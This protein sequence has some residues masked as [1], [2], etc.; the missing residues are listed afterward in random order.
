[1]GRSVFAALPLAALAAFLAAAPVLAQRS[2]TR[3]LNLG[4]HLSGAS[5]TVQDDDASSAGGGGV[6]AGYGINRRF[7]LFLQI[8]G[9]EFDVEDAE[10]E[11]RWT[12]AHV[13][14][15]ARFHFANTLRRWVPY[16]QAA[17]SGRRV[18][19]ED[20]VVDDQPERDVSFNGG[21][22]SAGGGLLFYF[23]ET[24]AVDLQ[25]LWSGGEF[26]EIEVDNVTVRGLDIDA[27]SSRISL[28]LSWWP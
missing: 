8:D 27:Q 18:G 19:V 10:V 22:F 17:L 13:D 6:F 5:L 11:G 20:A 4:V 21:A 28:G 7:T 16:L 3:G 26:S 2:T 12:M 15:G 24:L 25:V 23:K 14:L 9:A 1:M